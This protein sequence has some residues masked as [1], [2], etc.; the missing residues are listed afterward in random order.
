[1]DSARY[2]VKIFFTKELME[3][4]NKTYVKENLDPS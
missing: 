4:S 1:M 3:N 2:N